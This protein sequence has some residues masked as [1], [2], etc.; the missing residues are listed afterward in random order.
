MGVDEEVQNIYYSI[1]NIN[2]TLSNLDQGLGGLIDNMNFGLGIFDQHVNL[3][4][5]NVNDVQNRVSSKLTWFPSEWEYLIFLM[6]IGVILLGLI[7]FLLYYII[8]YYINRQ[9]NYEE[10]RMWYMKNIMRQNVDYCEEDDDFESFH[11]Q[12]ESIKSSD[13]YSGFHDEVEARRNINQ[14]FRSHI[15]RPY[16]SELDFNTLI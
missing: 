3:V 8:N 2:L 12:S 4:V 11:S 6:L 7:I 10:Y 13:V 14:Q 16:E 1:Y 5:R 15:G 9:K